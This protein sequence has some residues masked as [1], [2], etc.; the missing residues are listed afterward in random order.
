MTDESGRAEVY[1]APYPGTGRKWQVTSKGGGYP[2][3]GK[4][5]REV[6][7]QALDGNVTAASVHGAGES[8]SVA[9]EKALFRTRLPI[10]VEYVYQPTADAQR[11]LVVETIDEDVTTPLVVTLGWQALLRR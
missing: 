11:F 1:V 4:D 7:Y 5:G 6:L 3:W 8:F 10:T 9:S 2:R